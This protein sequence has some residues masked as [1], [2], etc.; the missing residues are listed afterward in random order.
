MES[1][2][3]KF[4]PITYFCDDGRHLVCEPYTRSNLHAMAAELGIKRCWFHGGKH[5]HYDVPKKMIAAVQTRCTVVS[6]RR[7]LA[8]TKRGC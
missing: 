3:A 6:S 4:I 1:D 7:I 5:P 2:L 8:I